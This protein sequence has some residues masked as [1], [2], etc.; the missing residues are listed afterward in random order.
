MYNNCLFLSLFSSL[1]KERG[2]ENAVAKTFRIQSIFTDLF[3]LYIPFFLPDYPSFLKSYTRYRKVCLEKENESM[4]KISN[5][6]CIV[7]KIIISPPKM[8]NKFGTLLIY[9]FYLMLLVKLSLYSS[10]FV[11]ALCF[12]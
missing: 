4:R 7:D 10:F 1:L 2:K 6:F 8:Q 12:F 5:M 3:S 9:S 11:L